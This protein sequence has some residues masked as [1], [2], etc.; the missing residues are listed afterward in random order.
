MYQHGPKL[1]QDLI[2]TMFCY[3]LQ[4]QRRYIQNGHNVHPLH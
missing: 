2:A 1:H 3:S 4:H